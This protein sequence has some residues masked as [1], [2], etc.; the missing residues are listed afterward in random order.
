MVVIAMTQI[1]MI[2]NVSALQV[3]IDGIAT[4]FNAPATIVGTAIVTYSLVVAGF[5]MLGA[6]A[7]QI[8]GA[9]RV[10]RA[11]I[12]LFAAAMT[13]MAFS[14]GPAAMITAEAMAGAAAAALVPT[15]V[16]LVAD[17]YRGSQQEEALGWL[18]GA[19]AMGIVLAFLIA[20]ALS[21]WVGWRYTFG[22]LV[23]LAAIIYRLSR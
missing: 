12:L 10:F 15:L 22:F 18:G 6:R 21:T 8:L 3:S 20:G 19:N 5:I 1:L 2:F 23:L 4:S 17:N 14:P 9:R 7:S 16:I 11:M 13:L